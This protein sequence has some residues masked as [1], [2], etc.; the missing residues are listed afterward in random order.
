[1]HDIS[2]IRIKIQPLPLYMFPI[3]PYLDIY[4]TFEFEYGFNPPNL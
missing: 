4:F 3:S 2:L 1:M